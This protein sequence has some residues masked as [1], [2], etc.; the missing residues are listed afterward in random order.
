MLIPLLKVI[1]ILR[2][3]CLDHSQ[4]FLS[5]AFRE[6]IYSACKNAGFRGYGGIVLDIRVFN[7]P[8]R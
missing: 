4:C 2:E 7:N 3:H 6:F 5:F 8:T 1:R